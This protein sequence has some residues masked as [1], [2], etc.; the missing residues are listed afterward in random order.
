MDKVPDFV[1]AGSDHGYRTSGC[2]KSD[3]AGAYLSSVVVRDCDFRHS[4]DAW[5]QRI[6]GTEILQAD[7]DM[8]NNLLD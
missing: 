6:T 8:G 1:F 3:R 5:K 2:E 7:L 4:I